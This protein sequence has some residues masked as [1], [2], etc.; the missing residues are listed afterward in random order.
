MATVTKTK[1]KTTKMTTTIKPKPRAAQH[2]Y[3]TSPRAGRAEGDRPHKYKR[4]RTDL[5]PLV[6]GGR[7]GSGTDSDTEEEPFFYRGTYIAARYGRT[8]MKK[9]RANSERTYVIDDLSEDEDLD[10][11]MPRPSASRYQY[12]SC[13]ACACTIL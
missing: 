10:L 4:V 2:K 3:A 5:E 7:K 11:I 8:S 12:G 6:S 13:C 1:T 9:S